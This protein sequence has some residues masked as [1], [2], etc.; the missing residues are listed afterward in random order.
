MIKLFRNLGILV[1]LYFLVSCA[2]NDA[3]KIA[4]T[5]IAF[6]EVKSCSVG[7]A[8]INNL[9]PEIKIEFSESILADSIQ[10]AIFLK[11]GSL[12]DTLIDIIQTSPTEIEILPVVDLT[13]NK[14]YLLTVAKSVKSLNGFGMI[15]D[16]QID[17]IPL[18][19][20]AKPYVTYVDPPD[21]SANFGK[22]QPIIVS[23]NEVMNKDSLGAN[24]LDG[25]FSLTDFSDNQK[26]SGSIS[27]SGNNMIF[28]P[29]ANLLSFHRYN[30]KV[31]SSAKDL[32]GN[33][34]DV[35]TQSSFIV[36]GQHIYFAALS[37]LGKI[38]LI[39]FNLKGDFIAYNK[40]DNTLVRYDR[41]C[42]YLG[43]SKLV[44]EVGG[45]AYDLSNNYYYSELTTDIVRKDDFMAMYYGYYGLASNGVK[46]FHLQDTDWPP[47]SGSLTGEFDTPKGLALNNDNNL[48]IVD[49]GNHRVQILDNDGS[50][51]SSFG[52]Y[53]NSAGEFDSPTGIVVDNENE[54]IYVVD[55]GNDRVQKLDKNGNYILQWGGSGT[56][57]G[58]FNNPTHIAISPDKFI[59]VSDTG[60]N[61]VQV[62]D[63]TGIYFGHFGESANLNS[64]EGI[65]IG[66][67]NKVY[68]CDT[69][70]NIV[71]IFTRK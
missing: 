24:G 31:D 15:K 65:G 45:L 33:G 71:K 7:D 12:Y 43:N 28:V 10:E 19:D 62:F 66:L 48:L 1:S 25:A 70:N 21:K 3:Y 17:F 37:G 54:F 59:Y 68:V 69:G 40:Y 42:L 56:D 61:R 4:N 8:Y 35:E 9:R 14:S 6:P 44:R 16:W 20:T 49:S 27:W 64:P 52:K 22:S 13:P 53:G 11:E 67:D 39:C 63:A 38:S 29:N 30:I 47:A 57:P 50:F 46:G 18:N 51:L 60:N 23:F 5:R 32:A 34:V 58:E 55:T 41:Y 2:Q 36:E 26:I